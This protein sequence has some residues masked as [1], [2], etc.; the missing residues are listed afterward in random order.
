MVGRFVFSAAILY[1]FLTSSALS[2][3]HTSKAT[4]DGSAIGALE[5]ERRSSA[6]ND[7]NTRTF[8]RSLVGVQEFE[9]SRNYSESLSRAST[10]EK[11]SDEQQPTAGSENNRSYDQ[12][13]VHDN[14]DSKIFETGLLVSGGR[15]RVRQKMNL[16]SDGGRKGL[17]KDGKELEGVQASEADNLENVREHGPRHD[18]LVSKVV[19]LLQYHRELGKLLDFNNKAISKISDHFAESVHRRN[20]LSQE[21]ETARRARLLVERDIEYFKRH[22]TLQEESLN[23]LKSQVFNAKKLLNKL[24]ERYNRGLKDEDHLREEF[25]EH[26]LEHWVESSMRESLN[27]IVLDA[28]MQGTEYVVEPMLEGIEKLATVND[29]ITDA[30]SR[31]LKNHISMAQKPFYSGFVSY[32]VLLGPLV[33]M[34]SFLTKIR[35]SFSQLSPVYLIILMS[36]Y[37]A[38]L[39]LGCLLAVLIGSVDVLQTFRSNHL[40]L[41]NFL[42]VLHCSVYT[43]LVVLH[44]CRSIV[45]RSIEG[46]GHFLILAAIGGHFISHAEKQTLANQSLRV[47][48]WVYLVYNAALCFVLFELVFKNQGSSL[49]KVKVDRLVPV[50]T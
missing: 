12:D 47:D 19:S 40:H 3:P 5:P 26:G 14:S 4:R 25:R 10:H 37:Y 23:H 2:A 43:L 31:S 50:G 38:L 34:M 1:V 30:V 18:I 35:R 44:L 42:V 41:F 20:A 17:P 16:A 9:R 45:H 27:P 22:A 13:V 46:F 6:V 24:V 28:I 29:E 15:K 33:I 7:R 36:F 32:T 8:Q 39:T 11:R 21:S 48:P 49:F